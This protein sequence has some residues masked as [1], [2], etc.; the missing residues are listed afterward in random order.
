MGNLKLIFWAQY[1]FF[2]GNYYTLERRIKEAGVR[3]HRDR[4]TSFTKNSQMAI[5][6]RRGNNTQKDQF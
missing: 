3:N 2:F 1:M 4:P 5:K 6:H